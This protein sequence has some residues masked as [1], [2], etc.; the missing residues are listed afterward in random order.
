MI[1]ANSLKVINDTA[2]RGIHM[3]KQYNE[4]L[5]KYEEQKQFI[6]RLILNYRKDI[7]VASKQALM[8]QGKR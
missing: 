2:E 1:C 7:P 8:V 4:A 3:I 5:T 6:L